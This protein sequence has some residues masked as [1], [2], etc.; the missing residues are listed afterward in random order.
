MF[1]YTDPANAL[2]PAAA[3]EAYRLALHLEYAQSSRL[4]K[5]AFTMLEAF[6]EVA[7]AKQAKASVEWAAFPRTATGTNQEIDSRRFEFQDEYVEWAVESTGGRVSRITFTTEFLAYY[8]ALAAVG[9]DELIAG[10]KAAIPTANPTVA[11]VFG[12]GFNPA[13]AS[14]TTRA[15]RFQTRAQSNPWVNGTKGIICL[16]HGSST[17]V[18]LF[19]LVDVAAIPDLSVQPGAICGKLGGNCVVGRNSDPNIAAAVQTIARNDRSLSLADPAGIEIGS[20]VGIWRQGT[21]E[22]DINDPAANGGLWKLSR[23]RRR[24]ELTVP[25]DLVLDDKS[26][27]S[28]AQVAAALR[29][30]S[31]VISAANADLPEWARVGHENSQRLSDVIAGGA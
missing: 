11:E 5:S 17:L 27:T 6:E 29:V 8:E 7:A 12:Q 25:A 21:R 14:P 2:K 1:E 9:A 23:G 24:G 13:V 20:L 31:N 18:A 30:R 19:R 15:R 10:I 26:I 16:A 3:L 22:I 4:A 28:G